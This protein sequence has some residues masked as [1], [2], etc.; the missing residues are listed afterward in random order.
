MTNSPE[1]RTVFILGAGCS[2]GAIPDGPGFP[3]ASEF[4]PALDQ[5]SRVLDGDHRRQIRKCAEETVQ[6]LRAERAQ[7]LDALA[8]RLAAEAR[9]SSRDRTERQ[10]RDRQVKAA[11]IATTAL[12][13][14]L[15]RKAKVTGLPR[16]HNFLDE[17]FGNSVIWN[18]S[19]QRSRSSVLT[20]N[21]DRLFEMAFVSRF[22]PDIGQFN[23]YGN[24]LLNGGL[25]FNDGTQLE[26]DPNRFALL[27]LH[28]T[29]G[30]RV[31]NEPEP[32]YYTRLDGN[33]GDD[34]LPINDNLFFANASNSSSC[35]PLL[36]F[37][38]E[39]PFVREGTNA[40]L[41]FRDYIRFVWR[42][43]R[44]LVGQATEIWAI[45]YRFAPIDREDVLE[46]LRSATNCKR[47]VIQNR[48]ETAENICQYLR[49][50]WLEPAGLNLK[51]EAFPQ[52]F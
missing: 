40:R 44:R 12:F 18:Q 39:K 47:L 45:G 37:P 30:I 20:F 28:G 13:L 11:K 33:P 31:Q 41:P 10:Q 48:P 38:H 29:V 1:S 14:D 22:K 21:Y 49:W 27:K 42:E 52:P 15:E 6:L 23:L 4:L 46:L 5:F 26:C 35:D 17:L 34:L 16:Y 36:V 9:D 43:A 51:V 2:A 25:D 32:H 50:R 7:T 24:S 3:L 19:S 8:A